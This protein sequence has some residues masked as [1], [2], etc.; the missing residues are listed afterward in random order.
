M[1][2]NDK[3]ETFVAKRERLA[4]NRLMY[5]TIRLAGNT[6]NDFAGISF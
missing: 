2:S 6:S 5:D 4:H 3:V 1:G